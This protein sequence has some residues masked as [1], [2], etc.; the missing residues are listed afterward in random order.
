MT[1][2]GGC[3]M[4]MSRFF[5]YSSMLNALWL[6]T[7]VK[8]YA[9][10]AASLCRSLEKL[11]QVFATF[12]FVLLQHSFY[13]IFTCADGFA[14][15]VVPAS[16]HVYNLDVYSLD[17]C[18]WCR[19]GLLNTAHHCRRNATPSSSRRV[20]VTLCQTRY[21]TDQ[22]TMRLS[23]DDSLP[24]S[25]A[26]LLD[27]SY[28]YMSHVAWSICL[29]YMFVL[30]ATICPRCCLESRLLWSQG[31]IIRWGYIWA[32]PGEYDWTICIRQQCRMSLALL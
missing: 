29:S 5:C 32:P 23:S 8:Y 2:V 19:S 16:Y 22:I 21:Q 20:T 28:V 12:Y 9:N 11:L 6:A 13:F 26:L 4:T 31:T 10:E 3:T 24:T 25:P 15:W 14:C 1:L 18:W 7:T 30:I 17:I 27:A